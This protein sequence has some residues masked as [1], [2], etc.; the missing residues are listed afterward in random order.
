MDGTKPALYMS[1]N[2]VIENIDENK[3]KQNV[4]YLLQLIQTI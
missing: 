4:K 1:K 2:D 3:L